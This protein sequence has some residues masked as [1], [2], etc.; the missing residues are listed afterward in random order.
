MNGASFNMIPRTSQALRLDTSSL[1][2]FN[3]PFGSLLLD[4]ARHPQ[5]SS[6]ASLQSGRADELQRCCPRLITPPC[7]RSS[8][9]RVQYT[10]HMSQP[11]LAM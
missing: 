6:A 4:D 5:P 10:N 8:S 3:R 7:G 1:C 11:C 2:D 9:H